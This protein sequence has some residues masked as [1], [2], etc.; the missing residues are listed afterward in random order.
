[1][2]FKYQTINKRMEVYDEFDKKMR[3]VEGSIEDLDRRFKM[4]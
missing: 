3:K 2:D 4:D 1:M